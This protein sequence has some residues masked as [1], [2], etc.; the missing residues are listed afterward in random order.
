MKILNYKFYYFLGV[1]GIGMSALARYFNHYQKKV[2]GYDKTSTVLTKQL[3]NEGIKCYYDENI[4]RLKE[5]L[6]PFQTDEVLII[7]TPAIPKDH[8]EW[9]YLNTLNHTILKRSEVLGAITKQFKTI[10]IAGTH[11]KTTTTTLVTHLLKSA[12]INCF[13]FMGGIS[14][15]YNTNL[16]LGDIHDPDAYVVVEADEYDRSFLTLE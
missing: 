12:G 8:Q 15:N 2:Y 13:S 3:E 4:E 7:Y 10:A 1:G 6:Q 14:K 5:L 11:G 16:L 9:L